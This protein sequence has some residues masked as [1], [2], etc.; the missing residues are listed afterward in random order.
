MKQLNNLIIITLC[1]TVL[2]FF[3]NWAQNDYGMQLIGYCMLICSVLLFTNA[4]IQLQNAKVI[5]AIYLFAMACYGFLIVFNS[6]KF[7]DVIFVIIAIIALFFPILIIPICV[8]IIERTKENKTPLFDY[9]FHVFLA[10]FCLGN[11]FKIYHFEGAGPLMAT[12]GLIIIPTFFYAI[13]A[14]KNG[15]KSKSINSFIEAFIYLFV[16]LDIVAF[17]FLTQHW[18][19]GKVLIYISF[20]FAWLA[21]FSFLSGK[22]KKE[23]FMN[24]WKD[25]TWISK[26]AYFCF[27]IIS[28]YYFLS[29][30]NIAPKIYSNTLPPSLDELYAKAN[31]ITREGNEFTKRREIYITNYQN[32]LEHRKEAEEKS[33]GNFDN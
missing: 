14:L 10:M 4:F 31:D 13:I 8:K 32:F 19:Y 9:T 3:A 28:A 21:I 26:T 2:G 15:F 16:A 27:I 17:V 6:Y 30:N 18:P 24:R 20:I 29:R 7:P 33:N 5:K 12:S 1:I 23:I 11:Y 22:F 25:L